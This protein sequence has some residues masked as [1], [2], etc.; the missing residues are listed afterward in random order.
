MLVA[1]SFSACGKDNDLSREISNNVDNNQPPLKNMKLK[2][3]IG[4]NTLTAILSDNPTARDFV[5]LLPLTVK[6]DD[7]AKTEK[8]LLLKKTLHKRCSCRYRSR[9]G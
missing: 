3:T 7:Y 2:I 9:F 5:A 8:V 6:L 1:C 4:N